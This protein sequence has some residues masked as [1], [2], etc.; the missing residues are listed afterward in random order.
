M[1]VCYV[2]AWLLAEKF[3]RF[4]SSHPGLKLLVGN[5]LLITILCCSN[6]K[7][8]VCSF[9]LFNERIT[10]IFIFV[11]RPFQLPYN[12]IITVGF[13]IAANVDCFVM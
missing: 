11:D 1:V 4:H 13:I 12:Q 3:E 6:K 7:R 9:F 2:N 8:V 10:R 5:P